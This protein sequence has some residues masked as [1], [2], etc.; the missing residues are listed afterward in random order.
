MKPEDL[1]IYVLATTV[2]TEAKKLTALQE[3]VKKHLQDGHTGA[4]I[5]I[6]VPLMWTE[7]NSVVP[8]YSEPCQVSD[9]NIQPADQVLHGND[10]NLDVLPVDHGND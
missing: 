10:S 6:L 7:G 9:V 8:L 4:T 3:V 5:G 2:V 1:D